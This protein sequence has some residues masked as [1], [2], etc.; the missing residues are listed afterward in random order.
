LSFAFFSMAF[1]YFL[2][3]FLISFISAVVILFLSSKIVMISTKEIDEIGE[4]KE[5]NLSASLVLSF[6]MVS[7]TFYLK[8]SLEHFLSGVVHYITS[9]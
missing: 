6:V 2:A 4:I 7:F 3:F 1:L 9:P 8:P 5:G